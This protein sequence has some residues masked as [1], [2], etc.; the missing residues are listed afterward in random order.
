[1]RGRREDGYHLLTTVLHSIALAD[2]LT[3]SPSAGGF[4]LTCDTPGVPVDAT[5]LAW[6]GAAAMADALGVSLDG[7]TLRLAKVVPAAAGLGGGS[8]DAVAAARLVAA[9]A[10]VEVEPERLAAVVRPI[11]ADVAYFAWGGAMRGEGIGDR[12]TPLDD[13]GPATVLVVRPA[14]GVSTRDAYGWYDEG[15][16]SPPAPNAAAGGSG[17]HW[18]NDLEAPVA[19]RHPEIR[20]IVARLIGAGAWH[21]AMSGSGSACYGLFAPGVDLTA[22]ESDWPA[23]T[24]TW[25]TRLLSRAE[26]AAMVACRQ[27]PNA[28]RRTSER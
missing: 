16:P 28:E 5:N 3:L 10:G 17:R 7:W 25:R 26:Y 22:S 1:M 15:G 11:G 4:T 12:L 8:A 19:D 13:E 27:T 21:A 24:T 14:F 9:A 18:A 2:T 6:K 23:G 20:V